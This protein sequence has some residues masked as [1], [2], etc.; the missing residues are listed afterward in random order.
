MNDIYRTLTK[1]RSGAVAL[2]G[3][4]SKMFW[5]IKI[6]DEDQRYH[7]I[8]YKGNTYV[9]TRICFGNTPSP[10]SNLCMMNIAIFGRESHPTASKV[11]IHKRYMDGIVDAHSDESELHITHDQIDNLIGK[12]GFEIKAWYSKRDSLGCCM[13]EKKFPLRDHLNPKD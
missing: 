8:I 10:I 1:F 13:D 6:N 2:L 3:D 11:L 12:F 7:G 4:I 9:F 5:Q